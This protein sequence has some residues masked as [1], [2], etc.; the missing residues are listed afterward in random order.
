MRIAILAVVLATLVV[1]AS[2]GARAQDGDDAL[3]T[4]VVFAIDD[5][6]SMFG[7][8][9]SDPQRQR[10]NGVIRLVEVL[11][12]FLDDADS[13]RVEIGAISF[14]TDA[15]ELSPLVSVRDP[16]L[17]AAL[18]AE[19]DRAVSRGATDFREA[20]CL[21]WETV[22]GEAA[23]RDSGCP[24]ATG[25][26]DPASDGAHRFV[27]LVT[28]GAP[29]PV[30]DPLQ[31]ADQPD[32]AACPSEVDDGAF[33]ETSTADAYLCALGT[34]WANL[35]RHTSVTLIVI[36]L[37]QQEQWFDKASPYWRRAVDCDLEAAACD[38]VI[39]SVD[40]RLAEQILGAYPT[41]DLCERVDA[42]EPFDCDVPGGLISVQFLITGVP[43]GGVTVVDD[44]RDKF[45]SDADPPELQTQEG[46]VHKWKFGDRPYGGAYRLTLESPAPAPDAQVF[47]DYEPACFTVG[48]QRWDGETGPLSVSL[49]VDG[50]GA[51]FPRSAEAQAYEVELRRDGRVTRQADVRLDHVADGREFRVS[52]D[53]FPGDDE[54]TLYLDLGDDRGRLEVARSAIPP[55]PPTPTPTSLPPLPKPT[56]RADAGDSQVTLS[57]TDLGDASITR[58]E[59]RQKEG[60]SGNYGD[61]TPVPSSD[62]STTTYTVTSLTNG[63]LYA[64][65]VRAV[66]SWENGIA[67]DEVTATPVARPPKP[68]VM[69]EAGDEQVT[70]SW[71]DLGD[72][73]ITH[74]EYQQKEGSTG[75]GSWTDISGSGAT[76][77]TH[78][79]TGLTN[80]TEYAF[81]V[82]AVNPSGD[83]AA[84]NEVTAMPTAGPGPNLL[85]WIIILAVILLLAVPVAISWYNVRQPQP[86]NRRGDRAEPVR[87]G[88]PDADNVPRNLVRGGLVAWRGAPPN[89]DDESEAPRT[90]M[91]RGVIFGPLV[92]RR[93]SRLREDWRGWLIATPPER[94]LDGDGRPILDLAED[95]ELYLFRRRDAGED[96]F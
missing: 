66:N 61:W 65:K 14:G 89:R 71:K 76:T 2:A 42:S 58:W 87:L 72:A 54:F 31:F 35:T 10:Y 15:S 79:V 50:D 38:R 81:K 25:T 47:V 43:E 11:D 53:A 18:R 91:L 92:V 49:T 3:P 29:A 56:V 73:N 30:S 86:Y 8:G 52:I 9:G 60:V 28:D 16:A 27:V 62:A 80:G 75:Y 32:P 41:I 34:V 39:R 69:A 85:P 63:V 83:G 96:D 68:T 94:D 90:V 45:R 7:A 26:R 5:S 23:P 17:A 36:G 1:G 22:T 82:R 46:G 6:G 78:T 19:R 24:A 93:R 67:S 77:T 84:S 44:G 20:L 48:D 21:A 55:A 95:I 40:D 12:Q 51:V 13:R 88:V 4:Q 70:L 59:Y 57:W 37:D 64:F 33:E 74:W